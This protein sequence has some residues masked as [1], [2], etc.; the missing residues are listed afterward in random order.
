MLTIKDEI[1]LSGIGLHSGE[2]ATVTLRPCDKCGIYFRGRDGLASVADAVVEEDC[3]LTGFSLPN[4]VSVRTGEHLLAAVVGMGID[5]IEI[6]LNGGEVPIMDGSAFP[7]AEAIK[8]TGLAEIGGKRNNLSIAVPLAVEENNGDRLLFALPSDKLSI[9]YMID[10][11]GTPIGF[12]KIKYDITTETFYNI[13]SRARTF[14]LTRELLYLKAN[15]LAKGGSLE[16][17]MVFDENGLVSPQKLRFPFECVTH[18]VIDLLG[19]LALTGTAPVGYYVAV[20][21]GHSIHGK[22]VRKLK[23]H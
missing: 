20:C 7:F 6:E 15:G 22:L 4:G 14:C 3:R 19:D 13:I 9:T 5:A 16:N 1:K 18:K 23:T 11:S 2:Y 8:E 10:Y 21:A 12:Q 17:A